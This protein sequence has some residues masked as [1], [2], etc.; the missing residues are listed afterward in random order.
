MTDSKSREALIE[1]L[2]YL[3]RKGMLN[4]NTASARKAAANKVFGI[5]DE[6][7]A[8][9]LGSIDFEAIIQRFANLEGKN[10]TPDSLITYK[11]RAKSAL[12]DFLL[13]LENP[14][15]FKVQGGRSPKRAQEKSENGEGKS[16]TKSTFAPS[17]S[18]VSSH[19]ASDFAI[20]IPIRSDLTVRI[21][22]L[23]FDLT[24][25]EATKISNV[26]LAMVYRN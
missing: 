5:L 21:S 26:I 3:T 18:Q 20:P 14:M 2:D 7:E 11:S 23:P 10:Y 16:S 4:S 24:E 19:Q 15:A 25:G 1:F 13:Y 17:A 6:Q 9:D 12:D 8:R 22:G